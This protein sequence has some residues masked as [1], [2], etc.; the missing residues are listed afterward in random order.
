[1]GFFVKWEY[2]KPKEMIIAAGYHHVG[3]IVHFAGR[4]FNVYLTQ[5]YQYILF[6]IYQQEMR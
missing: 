1:M 3:P 4:A 6:S 5:A 2:G